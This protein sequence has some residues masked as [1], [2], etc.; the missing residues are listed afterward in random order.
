MRK[1]LGVGTCD[2]H[3]QAGNLCQLT[4]YQGAGHGLYPEH[5]ADI[6]AKTASFL[7]EH[8]DLGP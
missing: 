3:R 5:E 8:L 6:Q 4:T 7:Y 2:A 1:L